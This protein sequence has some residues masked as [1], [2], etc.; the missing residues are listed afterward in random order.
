MLGQG[1]VIPLL[2]AIVRGVSTADGATAVGAAVAAF[3][4][5]RLV[6]SLPAGYLAGR[7][8]PKYL[9]VG[10]PLLMAVSLFGVAS[11][12]SLELLVAWRLL[13]GI[14]SALFITASL[15]YLGNAVPASARGTAYAYFYMAFS[16]GISAGPAFGGLLAEI[17]SISLPIVVVGITSVVSAIVGFAVVPLQHP[18]GIE[19]EEAGRAWSVWSDWRFLLVG[20]ISLL[21]YATRNGTQQTVVPTAAI[22]SGLP[23]AVL[24]IGFTLAAALTAAGGPLVGY[25]LDRFDRRLIMALSVVVLGFTILGWSAT[26]WQPASFLL[27]MAAYGIVSAV[28]DSATITNASDLVPEAARARSI[29]YFRVL[30][31]FGY[32]LGPILLAAVA[33]GTTPAVAIA[34]NSALLVVAGLLALVLTVGVSRRRVRPGR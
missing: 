25:L 24:G 21:V 33:D 26:D 8:G 15:I 28:V 34:A 22:D 17:H 14:S 29:G 5:A 9:M 12:G 11:A 23:L 31:D 32:L 13:A 19:R 30:S 4:L 10:G 18:A 27:T 20:L 6:A 16:A 3:G 2:P 1:V 7:I